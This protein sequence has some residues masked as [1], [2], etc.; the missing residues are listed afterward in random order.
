M[1]PHAS[2]K[3]LF[4]RCDDGGPSANANAGVLAA[5]RAGL[6]CNC[7]LMAVAPLIKP[8]AADLIK[9]GRSICIGLHVTL[10]SEWDDILYRPLLPANQ[11]PSLLD[12]RGAFPRDVATLGAQINIDQAL[13]DT[14]AQ[15]A[16]L[17]GLG[18]KV[19]YLD[20]HMGVG[21]AGG[22]REPLLQLADQEGL[23][24]VER[25]HYT[26]AWLKPD[27]VAIVIEQA[28]A[29]PH[30]LVWIKHPEAARAEG[31]DSPYADRVKDLADLLEPKVLPR[32]AE[33]GIKPALFRDFPKAF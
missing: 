32:L 33:A 13:A 4:I 25:F 12:S 31:R 24:A 30:P 5:A 10:T 22:L 6:P 1:P 8:L 3:P 29:S 27:P 28:L 11:V 20:E 19:E 14:R 18:L 7:S 15:L 9:L 16:H 26:D 17:R 21:W 2:F 23:V